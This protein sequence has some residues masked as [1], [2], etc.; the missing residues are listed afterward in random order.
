MEATTNTVTEE[1]RCECSRY[2]V[3]V[4]VREDGTGDLVWDEELTTGCEATARKLFAQGHDAKLKS[5][6]IKAGVAGHEVSRDDGGVVSTADAATHANHYTFGHMIV[7]GIERAEAKVAAKAER[8][9]KRERDRQE[10]ATRHAARQTRKMRAKLAEPKFVKAKV[11]RWV[12]EGQV[13]DQDGAQVFRY[14]AKDS[15]TKTAVK[16]KLV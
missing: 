5:F 16:F 7:A 8:K 2:S 13:M 3:L 10:T 11:G 9:A 14:I 15:T 1:N 4:N 6:L 12:Y